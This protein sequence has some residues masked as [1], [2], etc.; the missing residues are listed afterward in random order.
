MVGFG[1]KSF[2]VAITQL[3]GFPHSRF[4]YAFS[5]AG[6]S[7]MKNH[8]ITTVII[9]TRTTSPSNIHLLHT[10]PLPSSS[11]TTSPVTNINR[12]DYICQSSCFSLS[13]S[14]SH[15]IKQLS[16]HLNWSHCTIPPFFL[17]ASREATASYSRGTSPKATPSATWS[18]Y[19]PGFDYF[20]PVL[21]SI[22]YLHR[23]FPSDII[24]QSSCYCFSQRDSICQSRRHSLS[25]SCYLIQRL[26][27]LFDYL[28]PVL[29]LWKIR[30]FPT[31]TTPSY[32]FIAAS[33]RSQPVSPVA[34][35][36]PQVSRGVSPSAT[37]T[38]TFSS[39]FPW[40]LY[41]LLPVATPSVSPVASP[42]STRSAAEST[43]S[44]E[45]YSYDWAIV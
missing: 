34:S 11:P 33:E 30:L 8:L 19:L 29:H 37:P 24:C 2:H 5:Y 18:S 13:D 14:F 21:H 6:N 20:L 17:L 25:D 22:F 45:Y 38:A 23:F 41:N 12:I 10:A 42:S 36:D 4:S 26:S 1:T 28:L 16:T 32:T 31:G 35:A 3:L 39:I 9:T 27:L 15:I 43:E 7:Q 40:I 44:P